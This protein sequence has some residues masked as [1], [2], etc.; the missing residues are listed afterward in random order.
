MKNKMNCD[1]SEY[2]VVEWNMHHATRTTNIIQNAVD[3]VKK[4]LM[5]K[6]KPSIVILTECAFSNGDA[7]LNQIFTI[8]GYSYQITD[9]P[10][11]K[12]NNV[13]IAWKSDIFNL[14]SG[15]VFYGVSLDSNKVPNFLTVVLEEV[16]T[17]KPIR[18]VG[19]RIR[20]RTVY[21]NNQTEEERR[22]KQMEEDVFRRKQMEYVYQ[23]I[24]KLNE[25]SMSILIGGD[26]NCYRRGYES[27]DW[28]LSN[29][30]CGKK[31]YIV[32]TPSGGSISEKDKDYYYQLPEDNFITSGCKITECSYDR[33]FVNHAKDIY[34]RG[35]DFCERKKIDGKYKY[36]P[37]VPRGYPDHAVLKGTLTF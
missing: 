26:F 7:Y 4:H 20:T 8:N 25:N 24:E 13:V 31:G 2:T 10:K 11:D 9:N 17:S 1:I 16:A 32:H 12:H 15:S 33:S 28:S 22:R 21:C 36:V 35:E 34:K 27:K 19:V 23:E 18:V 5:K 30:T 6:C 14:K 37:V 3:L 29:L